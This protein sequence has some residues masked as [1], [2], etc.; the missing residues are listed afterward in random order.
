M[1]SFSLPFSD[2]TI[3]VSLTDVHSNVWA[4]VQQFITLHVMMD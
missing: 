1:R 4:A 3:E 2:S